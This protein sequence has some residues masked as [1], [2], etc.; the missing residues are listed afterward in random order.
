MFLKF[1]AY[2]CLLRFSDRLRRPRDH[3]KSDS[4]QLPRRARSTPDHSIHDKHQARVTLN[5]SS[6]KE[7]LAAKRARLAELKRQRELRQEQY[8]TKRQ[9][10]GEVC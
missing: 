7:E 6:L 4:R 8:S 3:A 5:M 2:P 10:I 9:S 1:G